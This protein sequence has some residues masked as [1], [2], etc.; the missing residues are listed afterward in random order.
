MIFIGHL[1]PDTDSVCAAIAAAKLY[2]GTPAIAGE[3]N[4][5]TE[6][7]LNYFN[8]EKPQ[9]LDSI[10]NQKIGIV[11]HNQTT[12]APAGY[13]QA[14]IKMIIDHHTIENAM[15]TTKTPIDIITQIE[16]HIYNCSTHFFD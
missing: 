13:E 7:V 16:C 9:I 2:N 8:V 14:D 4:K 5:E 10:S 12:Q 11:D 15:Y 6:Y 3:L 1:K